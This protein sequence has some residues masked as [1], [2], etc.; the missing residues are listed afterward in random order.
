MISSRVR[1]APSGAGHRARRGSRHPRGGGAPSARSSSRCRPGARGG[2]SGSTRLRVVLARRRRRAG[3]RRR[4]RRIR[5]EQPR[6]I[7]VQLDFDLAAV[8]ALLRSRDLSVRFMR[9]S[10]RLG[11]PV[12]KPLPPL[13]TAAY[14]HAKRWG[15]ATAA[16]SEHAASRTRRYATGRRPLHR[17]RTLALAAV[18]A[19]V[20]LAVTADSPAPALAVTNGGDWPA[21]LHDPYRTGANLNESTLSPANAASLSSRR[22]GRFG[23]GDVIAASPTVSDGVIFVGSWDGN[24]YAINT[25]NG[26]QKWMTIRRPGHDDGMQVGHRT[27]VQRHH[28]ERRRLRQRRRRPVLCAQRQHRRGALA[29]HDRR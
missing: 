15:P 17:R 12:K 8:H 19:I 25:S 27:N 18:A 21:Y 10:M 4:E 28:P 9:C 5:L 6:P 20:L 11:A 14:D 26:T 16:L 1:G 13:C 22:A 2:P 3:D 24:I 23:T 7:A 29:R